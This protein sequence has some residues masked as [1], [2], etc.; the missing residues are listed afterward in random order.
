LRV[1]RQRDADS[2]LERAGGFLLEREA[3]H[4]L[5]LGLSGRLLSNPRLY[6]EDPY[7]AVALDGDRA[8]A[9]ALRTPPHNLHLSE[10][11]DEAALEPIAA[12][13]HSA[14]GDLPGV[15]GSSAAVAC[16]ERLWHARTGAGGRVTL[17]QRIYE[18]S[19]AHAPKDVP[20]EMRFY[21]TGDRGLIIEWMDAFVREALPPGSPEDAQHWLD[22]RLDEQEGGI[23]LWLDDGR[24]VSFASYGG[25]TP[26]GI[27]VGPV[28]TPPD[29]RRR[30]Y[31]TALVGQTTAM[32]L[33]G[34]R[35]FCFLY[36]DLA[37]PT[38]NSIYPRVGYEPVTDVD[39][40]RFQ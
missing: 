35:R 34:G 14:F 13:V 9:A 26:N 3:E 37:N 38:S 2:F 27:R 21:E 4:N 5:I 29:E 12:D 36:T 16:F 33:E 40:L 7:F 30:G 24:P 22:R 1:E 18:A 28:Y 8:V 20:G 17:R 10:I 15:Q 6:G 23:V 19:E 31:A 25:P 39:L 11:D 32:L